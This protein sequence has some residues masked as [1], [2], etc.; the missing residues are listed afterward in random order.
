MTPENLNAVFLQLY[1]RLEETALPHLYS[2]VSQ[3]VTIS[4]GAA[5]LPPEGKSFDDYLSAADALL[6]EAKRTG[7]NCI[8]IR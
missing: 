1:A 4:A 5:Y 8:V 2:S 7:K 6:Y 3:I